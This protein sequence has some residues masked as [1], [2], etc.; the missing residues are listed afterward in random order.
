M[1]AAGLGEVLYDRDVE[2]GVC[3]FGGAPANFADHF[4]KCF[5]LLCGGAAAE[6]YVVSAVGDDDRGRAVA[7]EL[8]VRGLRDALCRSAELPTGLVDKRKDAAGVN[9]YEILPGAWDAIGWSETTAELA[10]RCDVAAF[11]SLAQ[12]SAVSHATI[13]RFLDTM[14]ASGRETLRVF[15]VN[16]RQSYYSSEV[17]RSSIERCNIL[18]ISDEEAERVAA[19]LGFADDDAGALCRRL[20]DLHAGLRLV[21]LT[22]GAAGSRIFGRGDVSTYRIPPQNRIRPVDT[23]GA[24]DSFTAAFCAACVAGRPVPEAQRFASGVAAFVCSRE[25]AT[26]EYPA[27]AAVRFSA[28]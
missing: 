27:D 28:L 25:S 21:I 3:T 8:A 20:L 17:L 16:I 26:P 6:V 23:V 5:R 7:A 4:L 22:E 18:K 24:G 2:T 9:T 11:G 15:D 1:V 10:G 14:I 12:R 19:C 13:L